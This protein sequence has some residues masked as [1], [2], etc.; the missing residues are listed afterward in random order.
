M[1]WI[2]QWPHSRSGRAASTP[3]SGFRTFSSIG[4][5]TLGSPT[6]P[7]GRSVTFAPTPTTITVSEGATSARMPASLRSPTR[8]SFGHFSPWL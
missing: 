7:S 6:T 8:T 2:H 1:N 3:R 4:D 5:V